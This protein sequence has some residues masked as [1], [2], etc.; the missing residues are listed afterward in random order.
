MVL[1]DSPGILAFTGPDALRFLNGQV[2][3]DVRLL[4]DGGLALPSCVTDAKGRLQFRV[5]LTTSPDGALW[6]ECPRDQVG[7]LEGRLTRYLIADD[8][9]V[10]DLSGKYQLVHFTGPQAGAPAGGFARRSARFGAEGADWWIPDG[11]RF[12]APDGAAPM[13]GDE[14]E[15]FRIA[16]AVPAW[17][18]ELNAGLLPPEAGLDATDISYQ[19]G[20]YIGQ[21]VISRIKYAGKLNQRLA[22]LEIDAAITPESLELV[23]ASGES[24]GALTSISPVAGDGRRLALAFVRRGAERLFVRSADGGLSEA[25]I[26]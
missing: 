5:M 23:S 18:R 19:K 13:S 12:D 3:Q 1:L 16:R 17:G 25:R 11:E 8:V 14:L 22:L 7:D 4:S 9:E 15:A 10:A 20:C 2:T 21:E 6:V 26:V 24:A